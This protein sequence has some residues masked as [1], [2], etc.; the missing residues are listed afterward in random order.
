MRAIINSMWC[1]E[2]DVPLE[3][4][5][6]ENPKCFGLRISLRIG[7]DEGSGTN[8][9]DIY[10]VTPDWLEL[11]LRY[12]WDRAHWGLHMLMVLEYDFD[13]I[14]NRIRKYI[15]ECTGKDFLELALK[16]S[17]IAAWEF[18]GKQ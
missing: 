8:D 17:R 3:K 11:M 7:S 9:F 5:Q 2:L 1:D 15:E 4:Y 10:V 18:D 6:P 16:I 14:N 13:L 12:E